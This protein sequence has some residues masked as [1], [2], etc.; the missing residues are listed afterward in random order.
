METVAP[1][2][3]TDAQATKFAAYQEQLRA[4]KEKQETVRAKLQGE[5]K[6]M[7]YGN[8]KGCRRTVVD[9]SRQ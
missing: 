6:K 2:A 4:I 7:R 5:L 8:T 3:M 1:E 9:K